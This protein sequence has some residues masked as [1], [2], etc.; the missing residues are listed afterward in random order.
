MLS[1]F[2]LDRPLNFEGDSE[3][4]P[5]PISCFN[6]TTIGVDKV[7]YSAAQKYENNSCRCRNIQHQQAYSPCIDVTAEYKAEHEY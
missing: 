3:V 1:S 6:T 2:E 5:L 4:Q 7:A